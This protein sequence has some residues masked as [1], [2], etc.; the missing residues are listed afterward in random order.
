M[1]NSK[2]TLKKQNEEK[3][4]KKEYMA[5]DKKTAIFAGII[6]GLVLIISIAIGFEQLYQ[7]T[8]FKIDGKK[9]HLQ[10]L[11]YFIFMAENEGANMAQYFGDNYWNLEYEEGK[12]MKDMAKESALENA[13]QSEILSKEAKAA[14]YT[15]TEDEQKDMDSSI[16]DILS[17]MS[18]E[19]LR[20]NG[21][22][23][24]SLTKVMEKI[25]LAQR[26][27]KDEID[28]LDIDDDAIKKTFKYEDYQ[29]YKVDTIFISTEKQGEGEEK[30]AV[31][32][33]EKQA[34]Y[35]KISD[36]LSKAKTS[37]D[38]SSLIGEEEKELTA[39]EKTFKSG[40]K[41]FDSDLEKKIITLKNNEVSNILE[42]TNGYYIVRM[43]NNKS[44][45]SYDEAV[46]NAIQ[47]EEQK[48]FKEKILDPLKE[49]SNIEINE[50]EWGKI[51]IGSLTLG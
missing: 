41:T 36:I 30:V 15:I 29:E 6:I 42:A 47:E 5:S 21:F 49:K 26:Y 48:Q 46:N 28:K 2:N 17:N 51:E 8:I 43:I 22:T 4:K 24:S 14:D 32:K 12:T 45:E 31:S 35:K 40:D 38:F 33:E 50:K 11:N 18:K 25:L 7:P 3:P 20:K 19:Q 34:A 9:F 23:K 16:E 1:N 44:T 13:I 27:E 39:S 10:D 37:T